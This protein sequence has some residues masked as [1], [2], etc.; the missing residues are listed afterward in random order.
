LSLI[1]FNIYSKY[2][3]KAAL[4]RFGDFKIG[5][6]IC[7]VKYADDLVLLAK[8]EMVLQGMIVRLTETGRCHGMEVTVENATVMRI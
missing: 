8:E 5:Q 2:L 7:T 4:E 3:T 1:H 6:L